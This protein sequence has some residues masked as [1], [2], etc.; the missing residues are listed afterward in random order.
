MGTLEVNIKRGKKLTM[1]EM[2]RESYHRHPQLGA[3][4][5]K[6]VARIVRLEET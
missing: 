1:M 6:E 2:R 4:V 3:V 5:L